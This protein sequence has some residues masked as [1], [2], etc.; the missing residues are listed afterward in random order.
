M[1]S[2]NVLCINWNFSS[3]TK[4]NYA[5]FIRITSYPS[6]P[7]IWNLNVNHKVRQKPYP[8]R[9]FQKNFD[10][11]AFHLGWLPICQPWHITLFNRQKRSHYF[12]LLPM[13]LYDC[14]LLRYQ[15]TAC[16]LHLYFATCWWLLGT[17]SKTYYV[18]PGSNKRKWTVLLLLHLFNYFTSG[19]LLASNF[20]IS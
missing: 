10:S 17:I 12:T 8:S 18:T 14:Y 20:E 2:D 16:M 4:L 3:F 11:D 6:I 15:S 9:Y 5:A 13:Y 7:P 1:E 19:L